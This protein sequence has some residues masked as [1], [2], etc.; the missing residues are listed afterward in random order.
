M[1]LQLLG[2]FMMLPED[3]ERDYKEIVYY[4]T[5]DRIGLSIT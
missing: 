5:E 3:A 4:H 2:T 1:D